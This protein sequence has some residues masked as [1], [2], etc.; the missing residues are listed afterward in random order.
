MVWSAVKVGRIYESSLVAA[1]QFQFQG[2]KIEKGL[3]A[4]IMQMF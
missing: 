2:V 3:E 4:H 1:Q